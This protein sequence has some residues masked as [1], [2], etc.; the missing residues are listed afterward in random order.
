MPP[1]PKFNHAQQIFICNKYILGETSIEIAKMFNCHMTTIIRILKIN[2]IQI[3]GIQSKIPIENFKKHIQITKEGCWEWT[4]KIHK[5]TG[6]GYFT[7]KGKTHLSHRFS[8]KYFKG[9]IPLNLCIDHICE[10]RKCVN[11]EHLQ[12]ITL[13]QN[14]LKGKSVCAQ[15]AKQIYCHKNHPLSGENLYITPDNRRQC[16]TCNKIRQK[17][18][19]SK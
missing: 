15:K 5:N 3:R 10:N 19:L 7:V 14:I 9:E 6:Y 13:K 4:A 11:P 2:N 17:K 18:Y 1:K 8:Y 12:A 16:K